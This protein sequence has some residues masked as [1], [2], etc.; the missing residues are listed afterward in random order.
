ME[1]EEI[2][3][4]TYRLKVLEGWIVLHQT[5]RELSGGCEPAVAL[6]ESMC[7]VPDPDHNWEIVN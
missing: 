6:S 5:S 7:F 1:W 2:A 4:S 3:R